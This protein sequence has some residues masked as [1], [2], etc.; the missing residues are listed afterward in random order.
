MI[1]TG[2]IAPHAT[3][4]VGANYPNRPKCRCTGT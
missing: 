2:G 4:G 1:I 3:G